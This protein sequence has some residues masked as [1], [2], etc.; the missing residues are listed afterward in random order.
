MKITSQCR[1]VTEML[2]FC[3]CYLF[4]IMCPMILTISFKWLV[5][6]VGFV[7][8]AEDASVTAHA[9]VTWML[10]VPLTAGDG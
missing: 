6:A 8:R 9:A 3:I 5:I 10:C 7:V 2:K 4:E 1:D